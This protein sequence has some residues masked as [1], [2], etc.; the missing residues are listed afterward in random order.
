MN[1]D[2]TALLSQIPPYLPSHIVQQNSYRILLVDDEALAR[3]NLRYLL[4]SDTTVEAITEA[5]NGFDALRALRTEQIDI[6][7]LDIQM[8]EM[9]GF[10]VLQT[11]EHEHLPVVV[12]VTAFDRYAIKAF[13]SSAADYLLKPVDDTRFVHA[14]ER[15]KT[16]RRQQHA[17]EQ[18]SSL[19]TFLEAHP[20]YTPQAAPPITVAAPVHSTP[21]ST[22]NSLPPSS[23]HSSPDLSPDSSPY[24]EH[25]T[26]SARGRSVL[27]KT[28]DIEW[29]EADAYYA[30]IHTKRQ[31]YLLRERMHVLETALDPALFVRIH[32]SFIV[33]IHAIHDV[34]HQTHSDGI[35]T[36]HD[37]TT[38]KFTRTY[39]PRLLLALNAR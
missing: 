13:E 28:K 39:K 8:P 3:E 11:I 30:E 36:L 24:W 7:F 32:R 33:N 17:T 31:T 16:L 22:P 5:S 15:A 19:L 29:I 12:F 1:S 38:L 20:L 26:L 4:H 18:F 37:G 35:V 21:H 2:S 10:D 25:I 27:V 34:Q 14:L 9:N 6:L 23:P